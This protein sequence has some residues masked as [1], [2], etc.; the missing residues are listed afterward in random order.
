MRKL[1]S[2]ALFDKSCSD[3]GLYTQ[4]VTLTQVEAVE[5]QLDIDPI[6][7]TYP[8][9]TKKDLTTAAELF[10]Y[11]NI[12][13]DKIHTDKTLSNLQ[14]W[15]KSWFI[16]YNDLF[17]TQTPYHIILTLNRIIKSS[18]LQETKDVKLFKKAASLFSLKYEEI[19]RM[20]PGGPTN[21]SHTWHHTSIKSLKEEGNLHGKYVH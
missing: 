17:Q 12:C 11:L 21:V 4:S 6:E 18:R 13:P 20:L 19:Q 5:K 15:F 3:D 14:Q 2:E 8:N 9:V 7:L 16:F 10:I 1:K